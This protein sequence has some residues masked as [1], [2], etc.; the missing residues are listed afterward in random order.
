M[1]VY[2]IQEYAAETDVG[3]RHGE[4][5]RGWPVHAQ[6]NNKK[7]SATD[8]RGVGLLEIQQEGNVRGA[9]RLIHIYL[10][11]YIFDRYLTKEGR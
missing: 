8:Y 9:L 6:G 10:K 7:F 2:V 5:R 1:I 11:K 4:S 3:R